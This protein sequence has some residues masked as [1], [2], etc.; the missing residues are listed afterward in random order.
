MAKITLEIYDA[1]TDT[2]TQAAIDWIVN[3]VDSLSQPLEKYANGEEPVF[4]VLDAMYDSGTF[5]WPLMTTK[6][7][8]EECRKA[9]EKGFW[10]ETI[11]RAYALMMYNKE[12]Y[13]T[14]YWAYNGNP[15]AITAL[16]FRKI[17]QQALKRLD[18]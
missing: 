15:V 7:L 6:D 2:W 18:K 9:A 4:E 8:Q 3:N 13:K 17:V 16:E 1:L 14:R 10:E 12:Y 11:Y 5:E